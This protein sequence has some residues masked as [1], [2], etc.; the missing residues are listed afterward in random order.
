MVSTETARQRKQYLTRLAQE[1]KLVTLF[2]KSKSHLSFNNFSIGHLAASL[3]ITQSE[4]QST[5]RLVKNPQITVS[6]NLT[7]L[8]FKSSQ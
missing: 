8:I 3:L 2:S 1:L 7:K 6:D 5:S 4:G